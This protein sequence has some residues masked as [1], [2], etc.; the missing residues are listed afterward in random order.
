MLFVLI[1]ITS[2]CPGFTSEGCRTEVFTS[3]P[4]SL[5]ECIAGQWRW[6]WETPPEASPEWPVY[7]LRTRCARLGGTV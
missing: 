7:L 3:D 1:V 6:R 4:M 5:E 2:L